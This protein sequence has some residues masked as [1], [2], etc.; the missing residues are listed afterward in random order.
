M[1][2][3]SCFPKLVEI[4]PMGSI[5]HFAASFTSRRM[6]CFT[7]AQTFWGMPLH[8]LDTV[9]SNLDQMQCVDFSLPAKGITV[10]VFS[11]GLVASEKKTDCAPE[12]KGKEYPLRA[13]FLLNRKLDHVGIRR[14]FEGARAWPRQPGSILSAILSTPGARLALRFSPSD[15]GPFCSFVADFCIP[16]HHS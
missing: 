1:G 6:R 4:H 12:I 8:F 3:F 9:S 13:A 16:S 10:S 7:S 5:L 14:T 11:P 15:E 2:Q